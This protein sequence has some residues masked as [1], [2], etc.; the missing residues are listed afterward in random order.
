MALDWKFPRWKRL[1]QGLTDPRDKFFTVFNAYR[2]AY[3]P[4]QSGWRFGQPDPKIQDS[5]KLLTRP[6]DPVRG[7]PL[8]NPNP[9]QSDKPWDQYSWAA[10][11]LYAYRL[12]VFGSNRRQPLHQP[13]QWRRYRRHRRCR[14]RQWSLDR[15]RPWVADDENALGNAV[16]WH[17]DRDGQ[18]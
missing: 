8:V 1:S 9:Q 4:S 13:C 14:W 17:L 16:P 10:S 3:L 12:A 18:L 5:E 7:E 15:R 6:T 2:V 11:M